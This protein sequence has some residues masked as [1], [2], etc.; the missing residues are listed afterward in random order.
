MLVFLK[1]LINVYKY[2]LSPFFADSCRFEPCCSQYA[3]DALNNHGFLKGLWLTINR[4][5]RCHPW[6]DCG[7]DPVPN[8]E[9][10]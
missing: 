8:Q 7:Y 5:L 9:K 4:L 6:G 10:L 2:A 3:L 1:F